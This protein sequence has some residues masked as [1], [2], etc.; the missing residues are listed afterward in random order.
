MSLLVPAA[1]AALFSLAAPD[2]DTVML[3]DGG[4]LRGTVV[5]ETRAGGVTIQLPDGRVER[6]APGEVQR[7][8]YGDGAVGVLGGEPPASVP[9]PAAAAAPAAP[10][11][12]APAAAPE[13]GVPPQAAVPPEAPPA[14]APPPPPPPPFTPAPVRYAAPGAGRRLQPPSLFMLAGGLGVAVPFGDAYRA[15][16]SPTSSSRSSSSTSRSACG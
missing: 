4:R 7:V 5:E 15:R 10:A 14:V 3:R 13:P 9:A 2:L 12:E 1:L 6:V 8:V 11:G 16:R